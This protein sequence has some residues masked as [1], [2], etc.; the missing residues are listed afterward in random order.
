MGAP[1]PLENMRSLEYY[2]HDIM[3]HSSQIADGQDQCKGERRD[4]RLGSWTGPG[5][6]RLIKLVSSVCV[7]V[8]VCVCVCV[9]VSVCMGAGWGSGSQ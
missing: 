7:S 5:H 6:T 8:C 1:S 3:Q 9:C 4:H 2:L